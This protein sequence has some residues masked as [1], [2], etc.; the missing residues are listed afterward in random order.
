M[1]QFTKEWF[2]GALARMIWTFAE[3][4]LGFLTV[5]AAFYE[6]EWVKMLSVAGVAAIISFLKSV[7]MGVPETKVDGKLLIDDSG[8]NTKWLLQVD[9]PV[10]EVSKMTSIRL[11]IDPNANLQPKNDIPVM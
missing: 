2:M 3:T 7:V 11:K 8:E 5:G 1:Q 9:T 4:A 6:V 10:D